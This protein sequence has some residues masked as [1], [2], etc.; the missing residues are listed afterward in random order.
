MKRTRKLDLLGS[1]LTPLLKPAFTQRGVQDSGLFLDWSKIVGPDIAKMCAPDRLNTDSTLAQNTTLVLRVSPG[2]ILYVE[3][4]KSQILEHLHRYYGYPKIQ[5]LR[6]FQ[7][8]VPLATPPE[9]NVVPQGKIP[10]EEE[11]QLERIA[12]PQ[13]RRALLELS[14]VLYP[15]A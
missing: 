13:L 15:P 12:C 10:P 5:S 4:Y 2:A 11:T 8:P 3:N 14:K 7:A 1:F 6:L 9:K